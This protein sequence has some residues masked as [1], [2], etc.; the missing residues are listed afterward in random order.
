MLTNFVDGYNHIGIPTD[1]IEKTEAFYKGLGFKLLW[2]TV[3]K[4]DRVKFL[5]WANIVIETYE[6]S[7]GAANAIGAIDHIALNCTDIAACVK[8]AREAG[9]EFREGPAYLPYWEHGVAYV[10]ILGPNQEIVEFIQKF[11]SEEE[12]ERMVKALG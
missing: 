7:A 10:T 11:Q 4:G 3:Y 2:E 1:D 8:E 9:Y 5:G 12:K 6:K